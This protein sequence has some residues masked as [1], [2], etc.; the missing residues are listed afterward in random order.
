MVAQSRFRSAE[1]FERQANEGIYDQS[2]A[3]RSISAYADFADTYGNDEKR[4][5]KVTEAK[6]RM[7][8][9]YLERARGLK[10]I[11]LFY[12]KRRQWAAAHTYYGQI[13]Q[14]LLKVD[15]VNYP[16]HEEEATAIRK[17]ALTRLGEVLFRW[18]LIDALKQY[19]QAQQYEN[20]NKP[21]S[22]KRFY[23]KVS[24]NLDMLPA[25]M[26]KAAVE[27]GLDLDKLRQIKADVENDLDR[28]QQLID[29]LEIEERS[30]NK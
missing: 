11:A 26:E 1:L 27:E 7:N 24:L 13:D 5:E 16:K 29:Q 12:E 30:K 18:R 20:K 2:M 15:T 4:T 21:Y 10:A 25:S 23:M 22:A 28:T 17:F 19:S 6:S 14:V 9:M 3:E 8:A